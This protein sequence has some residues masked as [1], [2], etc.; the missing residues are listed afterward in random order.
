MC[1]LQPQQ[2]EPHLK[3]SKAHLK[4]RQTHDPRL[5]K[6]VRLQVRQTE[7]VLHNTGSSDSP[8]QY[9]DGCCTYIAT[10]GLAKSVLHT[11]T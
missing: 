1:A 9:A 2:E 4:G 8:R 7:S 10:A 5:C 11:M 3:L 6:L